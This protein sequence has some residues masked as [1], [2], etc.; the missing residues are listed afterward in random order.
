MRP[1][2]AIRDPP[3]ELLVD[4]THETGMKPG[5]ER[6]SFVRRNETKSALSGSERA[7]EKTAL[8]WF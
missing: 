1:V 2:T 8:R 7:S 3:F 4:K 5:G 6:A